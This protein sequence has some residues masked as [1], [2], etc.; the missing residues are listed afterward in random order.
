MICRTLQYIY[1]VL[2]GGD[3]WVKIMMKCDT[4]MTSGPPCFRVGGHVFWGIKWTFRHA[5]IFCLNS[6]FLLINFWN[7]EP[8]YKMKIVIIDSNCIQ[9]WAAFT[10]QKPLSRSADQQRDTIR[11]WV[12]DNIL[13]VLGPWEYD[14]IDFKFR[15]CLFCILTNCQTYCRCAGSY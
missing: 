13:I 15:Q 1:C 7:C 3:S 2:C 6:N 8:N 11:D 10:K 4:K 9:Y 12:S 14:F 5:H